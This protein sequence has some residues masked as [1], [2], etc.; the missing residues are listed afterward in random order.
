[1]HVNYFLMGSKNKETYR[2]PF[3]G[4]LKQKAYSNMFGL[5]VFCVAFSILTFFLFLLKITAQKTYVFELVE[6]ALAGFAVL[7]AFFGYIPYLA[8]G[9]RLRLR[10]KNAINRIFAFL[11][12]LVSLG[13]PILILSA[14]SIGSSGWDFVSRFFGIVGIIYSIP[15]LLW[16][17]YLLFTIAVEPAPS[18]GGYGQN[19]DGV[20]SA[21]QSP[22]DEGGKSTEKIDESKVIEVDVKDKK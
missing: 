22:V 20:S 3:E 11:A 6:L 9:S 14:P 5:I 7:F 17:F 8:I 2:S 21:P 4:L 13:L 1:M 19:E 10:T 16:N 18:F 12:R 15:M